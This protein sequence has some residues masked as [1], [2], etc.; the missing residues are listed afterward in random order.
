MK[1]RNR[2]GLREND[3]EAVGKPRLGPFRPRHRALRRERGNAD[4]NFYGTGGHY[5]ASF[6]L[7][8]TGVRKTMA[9]FSF[10]RYF[11]AAA[12]ISS[13]VTA[14]NPSRMVFTSCG[15]LSNSVK[16]A[17]R[18]ISPYFGMYPPRPPS[19]VAK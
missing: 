19:S 1:L 5:A 11:L 15:S 8:L 12:W 10:R 6:A 7:A 9:R 4:C 13:R 17:R 3:F 16:H 2:V 18:C 14:R